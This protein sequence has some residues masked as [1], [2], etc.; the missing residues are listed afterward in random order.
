MFSK[1]KITTSYTIEKCTSCKFE[2]KREFK[3]GDF[4][5]K[6]ISLCDSCG[7]KIKVEKIFGETIEQ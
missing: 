5:F 6:E 2:S 7:G 1:N 3:K 4:L